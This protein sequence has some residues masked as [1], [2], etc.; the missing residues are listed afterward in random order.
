MHPSSHRSKNLPNAAETIWSGV[1]QVSVKAQSRCENHALKYTYRC[2]LRENIPLFYSVNRLSLRTRGTIVIGGTELAQRK[3]GRM[4]R[5]WHGKL[6]GWHGERGRCQTEQPVDDSE[7]Y[8]INRLSET[9]Y[10]S[11]ADTRDGPK[12]RRRQLFS[13]ITMGPQSEWGELTIPATTGF[14]NSPCSFLDG[15]FAA[16]AADSHTCRT[17]SD[18]HP[19][20]KLRRKMNG[21][22]ESHAVINAALAV[23]CVRQKN[24]ARM[25]EP[26]R[27]CEARG[28]ARGRNGSCRLPVGLLPRASHDLLS[29]TRIP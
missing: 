1:V 27:G 6:W 21:S 23:L 13:A 14:G 25:T 7:Q 26:G 20:R 10:S 8:R 16:L 2:S 3:I 24:V 4:V 11:T 17:S 28:L 29:K 22:G 9:V 12:Q 15:H 18:G 5:T 19:E